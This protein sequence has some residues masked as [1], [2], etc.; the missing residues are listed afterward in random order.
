MSAVLTR[1]ATLAGIL[2]LALGACV[3]PKTPEPAATSPNPLT[4]GNVQLNLKAGETTQAQVL[5]AFGAP[6]VTTVGASG[7]EIWTYQRHATVSQ[8]SSKRNYWTVVL[9]GGSASA[10]GFEQT[11]RTMT[12]IVRFDARKI[13]SDFR[14][15][16]AEF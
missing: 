14:S 12:L 9:L 10:D 13:V 2:V 1:H 6:N 7:E 3:T 15:R 5:E 4:H 16:S 8:S 11:Q